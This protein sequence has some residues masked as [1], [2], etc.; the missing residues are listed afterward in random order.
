MKSY[1]T[2]FANPAHNSQIDLPTF[3]PGTFTR[4]STIRFGNSASSKRPAFVL[5]SPA[6]SHVAVVGDGLYSP[7][8]DADVQGEVSSST[9]NT[10][11]PRAEGTSHRAARDHYLGAA[12]RWSGHG[13]RAWGSNSETSPESLWW[14]QRQLAFAPAEEGCLVV[15][16]IEG[17]EQEDS[18]TFLARIEN[19]RL[20]H[21]A[22]LDRVA[23]DAFIDANGIV[24]WTSRGLARY[25]MPDGLLPSRFARSTWSL[26]K[27]MFERAFT[28]RRP[29]NAMSG[30]DGGIAVV[31]GDSSLARDT[32]GEQSWSTWLL[33]L[34]KDGRDRWTADV[35]WAV[36]QPPI[37]GGNGRVYLAGD[38]L[39]AFDTGASMWSLSDGKRV[40]GTAFADGGIAI[41][42]G[43]TLQVY[44]RD[45]QKLASFDT[46]DGEELITPPAIASDGSIWAASAAHLYVAR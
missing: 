43:T 22:R 10:W 13:F 5:T 34:D 6:A 19:A 29:P 14:L 11:W 23:T 3:V 2:A 20:T 24:V 27:P 42:R 39:E 41:T 35:P 31:G 4:S 40:R 7:S 18:D 44:A 25:G 21:G 38:R 8:Q 33:V 1:V 45:G 9:E 46:G 30:V 28:D 26:A 17:G 37:D 12:G 32:E 36:R 15:L 16:S